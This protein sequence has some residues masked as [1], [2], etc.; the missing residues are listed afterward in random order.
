MTH[1]SFELGRFEQG[2]CLVFFLEQ[3]SLAKLVLFHQFNQMMEDGVKDVYRC[4]VQPHVINE[5][6]END[7][8]GYRMD[9]RLVSLN[10]R[11]F[12]YKLVCEMER[13]IDITFKDY[14]IMDYLTVTYYLSHFIILLRMNGIVTRELIRL[15]IAWV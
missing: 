5:P 3:S 14:L 9:K 4:C 13:M 10:V 2:R 8:L 11:H 15:S 7:Y 1:M 12:D 6:G